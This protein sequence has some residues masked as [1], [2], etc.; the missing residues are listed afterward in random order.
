[1]PRATLRPKDA[2]TLILLR[3][4]G[5][6]HQVL[7]GQRH[8]GHV[9]MPDRYVFPGGRVERSDNYAKP[10][11]PLAAEVCARVARSCTPRRAQALAL[12]AVRETFEETGLILGRPLERPPKRPPGSWRPFFA[13]GHAPVLDGLEYVCRAITPPFRP[14]RFNTRFFLA[15]EVALR[16]QLRGNGELVDLRWFSLSEARSLPIPRITRFV[17]D[18]VEGIV[19]LSLERRR[20]RPIPLVRHVHGK[21]ILGYE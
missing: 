16:G 17:L 7:M 8:A 13:T 4:A 20:A 12:A 19:T 21:R 1:M 15:Q 9:F 2:A 5:G 3:D 14:R 18:E 10:A 11:L 6:S